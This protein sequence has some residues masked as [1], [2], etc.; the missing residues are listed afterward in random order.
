MACVVLRAP[1][2]VIAASLGLAA[3]T[4]ETALPFLLI[5]GLLCA[6]DA[7][8]GWLPARRWTLALLG[9]AVVGLLLNVGFNLF[10]FGDLTNATYLDPTSATPGIELKLRYFLSLWLAPNGGLLWYWM[11]A[12]LVLVAGGIMMIRQWRWRGDLRPWLPTAVVIGLAAVNAAGLA[13]WYAPF[14]W[15][16]WGPRPS[17]PMT[18][19]F[20]V[21]V[22]VVGGSGLV[23]F[24][25]R[26]LKSAIG[27][28]LVAAA[29]LVFA[30]PQ[31]GVVWNPEA[32]AALAT[33]DKA[34]PVEAV[35]QN[36]PDYYYGCIQHGAWRVKPLL[37]WDSARTGSLSARMAE[38]AL[39]VAVVSLLLLAR[40]SFSAQRSGA[41]R[42]DKP[43]DRR[44]QLPTN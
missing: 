28:T 11:S 17:I 25:G 2:L 30:I 27:F 32:E 43:G 44:D 34:C 22:A 5:L 16:A 39:A 8:D 6:R 14:G 9:G 40:R 10:R 38:L 41:S 18:P 15:L 35:V 19:A 29:V 4:K 36:N 3:T 31:V 13:S 42:G 37:L 23:T 7:D 12:C 21:A 1:P 24:I 26:V 33:F 20:V